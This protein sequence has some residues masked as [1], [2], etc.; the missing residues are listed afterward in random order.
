ML[1]ACV[2]IPL[3][4]PKVGGCKTP[5]GACSSISTSTPTAEEMIGIHSVTFRRQF[6]TDYLSQL[7]VHL[8]LLTFL[9]CIDRQF[10]QRCVVQCEIHIQGNLLRLRSKFE[11][12]FAS[13]RDFRQH[14]ASIIL[15]K[16][17][18]MPWRHKES[19]KKWITRLQEDPDLF[20]TA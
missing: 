16:L 10:Y 12:L 7:L 1:I 4:D 5:T 13:Q 20:D 3:S 19:K 8:R 18:R 15:K 14:H 2:E 11:R 17:Q 9:R 6:R